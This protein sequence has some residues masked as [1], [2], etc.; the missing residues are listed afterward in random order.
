MQHIRLQMND[1][2]SPLVAAICNMQYNHRIECSELH[3]T[4]ML[5]SLD[6]IKIYAARIV[7]SFACRPVAQLSIDICCPLPSS[8]ANQPHAAAAAVDRRDRQT[9]GLSTVLLRCAHSIRMLGLRG[10]RIKKSLCSASAL[11][12][13]SQAYSAQ[14][15]NWASGLL[16]IRTL[17]REMHGGP[18]VINYDFINS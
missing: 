3:K 2:C 14:I 4:R 9:D 7:T 11:N 17:A 5:D 8:A 10:R 18:L 13:A 6:R 1:S 12:M 16:V 15:H